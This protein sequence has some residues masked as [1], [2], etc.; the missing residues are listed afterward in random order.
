MNVR[1]YQKK[2]YKDGKFKELSPEILAYLDAQL[3]KAGS[4]PVVKVSLKAERPAKDIKD[5]TDLF[6]DA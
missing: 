3:G 2:Q 6:K 4:K 1:N 5:E